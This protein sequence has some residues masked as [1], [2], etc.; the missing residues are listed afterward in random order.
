[1]YKVFFNSNQISLG[2]QVPLLGGFT[3]VDAQKNEMNFTSIIA[4]LNAD[5]KQNIFVKTDNLEKTWEE[6][7]AHFTLIEAAGGLVTN[8]E[9]EILFINRLGKWD[10]PKGKLEKNESI[11]QCAIREVEEEC[12]IREVRITGNAFYTYHTYE[13]NGEYILKKTHW[14]KMM[15]PKKQVLTPQTEED[16]TEVKWIGEN[17]MKMVLENTYENILLVLEN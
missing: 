8:E 10:L 2:K 4:S 17:E 14:Y 3:V 12:G 15:A 16:I 13:F 9:N 6:F 11:E 5:E 7:C 1:M